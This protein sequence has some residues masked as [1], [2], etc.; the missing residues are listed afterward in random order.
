MT[1]RK[2]NFSANLV[3][4]IEQLEIYD[5]ASSALQLN[6]SMERIVQNN[7]RSKAMMSS[8]TFFS[9]GSSCVTL[10]KNMKG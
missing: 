3:R 8:S 1:L 2:Y 10:W 5:K 4:T 7:S 6:G 9:N